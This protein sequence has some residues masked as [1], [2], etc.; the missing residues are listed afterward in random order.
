VD[1]VDQAGQVDGADQWED[2]EDLLKHTAVVRRRIAVLLQ[3]DRHLVPAMDHRRLA[4]WV[5][6]DFG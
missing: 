2:Q 1:Q 4:S 5:G 6:S 3:V